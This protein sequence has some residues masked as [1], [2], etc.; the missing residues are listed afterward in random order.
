MHI[1]PSSSKDP[2]AQPL[3]QRNARSLEQIA[4][5]MQPIL[6]AVV[7]LA[8]EACNGWPTLSQH[9]NNSAVAAA[10]LGLGVGLTAIPFSR[11]ATAVYDEAVKQMTDSKQH[12][13]SVAA[14]GSLPENSSSLL[15]KIVQGLQVCGHSLNY[16][17]SD[18]NL[19]DYTLEQVR[20]I[21]PGMTVGTLGGTALICLALPNTSPVLAAAIGLLSGPAGVALHKPIRSILQDHSAPVG[22]SQALKGE[23]N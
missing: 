19:A 12:P 18:S 6:G 4:S 21:V 8:W 23:L 13:V 1:T 20:A 14:L 10:M 2:S 17:T 5:V 16:G 11:S 7:G 15:D 9:P 3:Q 22:L